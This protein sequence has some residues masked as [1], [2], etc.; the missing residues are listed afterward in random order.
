M[1]WEAGDPMRHQGLTGLAATFG[2]ETLN[3]DN[4]DALRQLIKAGD[5]GPDSAQAIMLDEELASYLMHD[6]L[7]S[8]HLASSM[9]DLVRIATVD[10]A[11]DPTRPRAQNA[12][13]I[14]SWALHYAA[15]NDLDDNYDEELGGI[16]GT[17]ITDAYQLT[18]GIDVHDIVGQVPPYSLHDVT[19]DDLGDVLNHIGGNETATSIVGEHATRLNQLLIDAGAQESLDGRAGGTNDFTASGNDDPLLLKLH[20]ASAFR[21]YLEDQLAQG[22]HSDGVEEEEA[23]RKTA[24]CSRCRSTSSPPT[25][26]VGLVPRWG[27]TCSATSRTRSSTATSVT[28]RTPRPSTRTTTTSRRS[29]PPRSRRSTPWSTRRATT[30]PT[31]ARCRARS[32]RPAAPVS[33]RP[34]CTTTGRATTTAH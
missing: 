4:G 15:E 7:T 20:G 34:S 5:N 3:D 17:Y 18:T 21:G 9:D 26:W 10:S 24:S 32:P 29:R 8:D 28:R 2:G 6:R 14:S 25:S 27:T 11:N 19:R 30:P 33:S 31:A 23:R 12:A 16:V 13:D 1:A 22:M